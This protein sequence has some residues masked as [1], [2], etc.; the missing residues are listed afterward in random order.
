M[1]D[2]TNNLPALRSPG[3][4][5][6][7]VDVMRPTIALADQ[8][9]GTEFV[10][11]SYR[12]RTEAVVATLLHGRELGLGPMTA[13]ALTDSI[14]GKPSISAEGARALALAAGHEIEVLET[15]SAI[16]R[17]RGRRAGS[18]VWTVVV[19]TIDDAR[20]AGL[21]SKA[22]WRNHPRRMLQARATGELCH[23]IFPDVLHGLA[24]GDEATDW[25]DPTATVAQ[26]AEPAPAKTRVSRAKKSAPSLQPVDRVADPAPTA[27]PAPLDVDVE[28][29]E[30][31]AEA[32]EKRA[33]A[34]APSDDPEPLEVEVVPNEAPAAP[35]PPREGPARKGASPSQL[36]MLN[37]LL[38]GLE[39]RDDNDRY[40]VV[41]A[42]IGREVHSTGDLAAREA[43]AV[44]DD[45]K[46]CGSPSDLDALVASRMGARS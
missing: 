24:V 28:L 9:A 11:R 13:L 7:W 43:S 25:D 23:L 34:Q 42:L 22:N 6:S 1:T 14:E 27:A 33:A 40:Q 21:L 41:G 35:E 37:A 8:V 32:K 2:Q 44:I 26:T 4:I 45:I 16:C 5:D 10:P 46:G 29:A 38:G 12:G 31:V 3:G 30:V 18:E 20:Q 17:V 19:W 36:R 39:V 15:S